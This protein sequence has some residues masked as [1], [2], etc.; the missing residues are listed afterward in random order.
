MMPSPARINGR[1]HAWEI[2]ALL[3]IGIQCVAFLGGD[4]LVVEVD[5]NALPL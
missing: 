2:A 1:H 5:V 3:L 4:E